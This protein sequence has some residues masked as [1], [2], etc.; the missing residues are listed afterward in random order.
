MTIRLE[1]LS[2]MMKLLT[3]F[4]FNN[5]ASI[6]AQNYN[7][8]TRT[9]TDF[10]SNNN[11]AWNLQGGLEIMPDAK[12]TITFSVARKTRF[13][14][15]KD[16]YSYSLGT[17][18]PNPDLRSEYTVNYDLGYKG[19]IGRFLTLE[20]S[21]FYSHIGNTILS[22][23]NVFYDSVRHVYESQVQNVGKSEYIGGEIGLEA[24]L[25]GG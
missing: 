21:L 15:V 12:N 16:R 7:S 5:R 17:A 2:N 4:S 25:G 18:I 11:S 9:I 13:A 14:T 19:N 3:G 10:P 8:T 1:G 6:E 22:V 23:N 24:A 20:S